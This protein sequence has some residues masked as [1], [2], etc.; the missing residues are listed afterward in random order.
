M[1]S[2]NGSAQQATSGDLSGLGRRRVSAQRSGDADYGVRRAKIIRAAA[3]VMNQK[4]LRGMTFRDI[5]LESGMDRATIYYYFRDKSDVFRE[6][7]QDGLTD[8]VLGVEGLTESD[9]PP[10]E[11]LHAAIRLSMETC[12]KHYPFLYLYFQESDYIMS[13]SPELSRDL[14]HLG[15]R[16]ELALRGTLGDGIAAGDFVVPLN[17]FV[18]ANLLIGMVNW[19]YRWYQPEQKFNAAEI[20]DGMWQM[21]SRGIQGNRKRKQKSIASTAP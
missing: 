19:T 21:V 12:E 11:R 13:L 7:I 17:K 3:T 5:A 16:Y 6:A 2:K 10:P 18:V 9:L 4:G 20:A 14:D 1:V 15:H 8:L